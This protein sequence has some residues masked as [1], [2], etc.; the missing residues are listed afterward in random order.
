MFTCQI[1]CR[2]R[3]KMTAEELRRAAC[4]RMAPQALNT[5]KHSSQQLNIRF[6]TSYY[7]NEAEKS[8]SSAEGH[9][10]SQRRGESTTTDTRSVQA[11]A[12]QSRAAFSPTPK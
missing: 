5:Q 4:R 10:G 3:L 7:V 8:C 6:D 2:E 1:K 12:L 9:G 11:S